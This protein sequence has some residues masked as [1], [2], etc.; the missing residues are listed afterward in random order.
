MKKQLF[1]F[2]ALLCITQTS[3][4]Q[5]T[6]QKTF[7][8]TGS[9]YAYSFQRTTDNGYII[10]GTTT[11]SGAGGEDIYLIKTNVNGDTLWTRTFGGANVDR[12]YT[13]KQTNDGG[14]I[15]TGNTLSFGAGD[16]DAYLIK[17]DANGNTL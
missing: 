13:V 7:G 16:R 11:S 15:I 10:L 14:Y 9:E 1:Y 5:L 17:T 3:S 6:F 12:G 8:G 4:A 2:L